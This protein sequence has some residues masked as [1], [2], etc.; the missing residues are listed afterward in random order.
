[1]KN[2]KRSITF[3]YD[4]PV[5]VSFDYYGET[6][7]YE[8]TGARVTTFENGDEDRVTFV[9]YELTKAG[10]R[11]ARSVPCDIY[12]PDSV[13]VFIDEDYVLVNTPAR[14]LWDAT[15]D[16]GIKELYAPFSVELS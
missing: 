7:R 8:V 16:M 6:R 2:I 15:H 5:M 11:R 9:G 3:D 1:M 4:K 10:K 12:I 14:A 13:Y